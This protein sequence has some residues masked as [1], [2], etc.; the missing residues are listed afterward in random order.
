MAYAQL[1]DLVTRFGE[2]ELM[3]QTDRYSASQVDAAMVGRLL[4]D[5]SAIIDGYLVARYA[6]P[7]VPVPDL[8]VGICCDLARYALYP[9]AAP[10]MVR[11]RYQN[12][13]RL[14]R[15]IGSGALQLGVATPV[16]GGVHA[17]GSPR[18]FGRGNR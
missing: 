15:E 3:A 9:D 18:L 12:A 7:M 13:Q 4:G 11:E 6:L 10:D 17:V 5:A 14:L 16:A 2:A 8:L 1:A